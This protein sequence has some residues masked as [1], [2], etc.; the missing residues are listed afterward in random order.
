M[1][2]SPK[3]RFLEQKTLAKQFLD[4]VVSESFLRATEYA[5]LEL[6]RESDITPE[7]IKGA[8]RFLEILRNLPEEAKPLAARRSFNLNHDLK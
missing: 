6:I 2:I 8:D 5:M 4:T 1:N 3:A 7:H